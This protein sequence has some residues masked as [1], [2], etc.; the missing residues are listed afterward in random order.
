MAATEGVSTDE[1]DNFLVVESGDKQISADG[2]LSM[3]SGGH[4]PCGRKSK[5]NRSVTPGR[6]RHQET[7]YLRSGHDLRPVM[8]RGGAHPG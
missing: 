2:C 5:D 6:D 3:M 1:R 8:R 4:T 7:L